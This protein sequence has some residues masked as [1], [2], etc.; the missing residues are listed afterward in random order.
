MTAVANAIM[1][2]DAIVT[3]DAVTYE[4][5]VR[6]ARLVPSQDIATYRVSVPSGTVQDTNAATWMLELEGLQINHSNGLAKALRDAEEAG[7]TID[8]TI[9]P[10]RGSAQPTATVVVTPLQIPF[11]GEE[12]KFMDFDVSLPVNGSPTFGTSA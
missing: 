6:K 12:G 5:Q 3:I 10:K 4:G 9:Q 11:G 7:D 1:W 2:K 8:V